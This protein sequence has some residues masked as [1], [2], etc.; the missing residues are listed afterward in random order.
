MAV[1]LHFL[2]AAASLHA[3]AP[4]HT[5]G[6]LH[7]RFK[8]SVQVKMAAVATIA[9]H[10]PGSSGPA[11]L[12]S[13]FGVALFGGLPSFAI[14]SLPGLLSGNSSSP[15]QIEGSEKWTNYIGMAPTSVGPSLVVTAGGFLVPIGGI[16]TGRVCLFDIV[17]PA[18]PIMTQVSTDKKGWFYHKVVWHDMNLD[19]RL[20]LV[21]AR[22]TAPSNPAGELV[23]FEQPA[24]GAIS[25]KT[26]TAPPWP[27][28]VVT[29]GPDVDFILEDIDGDGRAEVVAARESQ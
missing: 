24:R 11:L 6:S 22:A 9:E 10:Y 20:D 12:V 8:A 23:W 15:R 19:G 29:S 7:A 27:V 2:A 16:S 1:T 3:E 14:P 17:E 28:H 25:N 21:A 13:T 4:L 26:F 18:S 5:E